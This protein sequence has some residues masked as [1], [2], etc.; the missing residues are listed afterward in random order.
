MKFQFDNI[1][2]SVRDQLSLEK[3]IATKSGKHNFIFSAMYLF[4]FKIKYSCENQNYLTLQLSVATARNEGEQGAVLPFVTDIIWSLQL[5]T[6][7]MQV[8]K[9]SLKHSGWQ[10]QLSQLDLSFNVIIRPWLP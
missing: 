8:L 5:K 9:E 10:G 6:Q 3:Y 4:F 7:L 1:T 2:S